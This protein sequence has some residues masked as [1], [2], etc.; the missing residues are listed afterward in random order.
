MN[1]A[2]KITMIR[3]FLV[4]LFVFFTIPIPDWIINKNTLFNGINRNNLIIATAIFIIAAITD[5]LDGY[6]ARKYNQVTK[7]GCLIDPLADKLMVASALLVLVQQ[8]KV[9]G[10]IA[11]II[12][13]REI[14]VTALRATAA[15]NKKVLAADKYGKIKMVFQVVT[16]PL[17][18][19]NNYL[20]NFIGSYPLDSLM[21]YLTVIIT[22]VSGINYFV[23]NK[24]VL[25][26]CDKLIA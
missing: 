23:K 14:A 26:G 18:L 6:I 2:N 5:K 20:S 13:T 16:I 11:L 12:L 25:Y 4:P 3:I 17:C 22:A 7:F 1:L 19:L 9:A 24:E 15:L 8:N 10:W 21:M